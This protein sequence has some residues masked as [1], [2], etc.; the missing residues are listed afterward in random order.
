MRKQLLVF[1]FIAATNVLADE[2]SLFDW[3]VYLNGNVIRTVADLPGTISYSDGF[4]ETG[5]GTLTM[6]FESDVSTDYNV[7]IFFDHEIDE[8][9]NTFYNEYGMIAGIPVDSRLLY[10]I[11]EPGFGTDDSYRDTP[12]A[13]NYI[14]DI[15]D[16]FSDFSNRGF[17]NMIYYDDHTAASLYDFENSVSDDVS[18][19]MGWKF[20]LSGSETAVL[21]YTLSS[22]APASGFYLAQLDRNSNDMGIYLQSRLNISP[23]NVPEPHIA[24]LAGMGLVALCVF[25]RSK[26]V[27]ILSK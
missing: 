8:L 15:Y 9:T 23:I 27:S 19:A 25:C 14:G 1:S 18:M 4:F 10:E 2:I 17:D 22:T 21:E 13:Y 24:S 16:N 7:A 6:T 26:K 5:L 20:L 11:D 3:S 12:D